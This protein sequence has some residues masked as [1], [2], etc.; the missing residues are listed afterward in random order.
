MTRSATTARWSGGSEASISSAHSAADVGH[1]LVLDVTGGERL[2]VEA[3]RGGARTALAAAGVVDQDPVRDREQPR[4][5]VRLV[6]RELREAVE[7]PQEHLAGE[8]LRLGCALRPQVAEHPSGVVSNSQ[9]HAHGS[10]LSAASCSVV[11]RVGVTD[12]RSAADCHLPGI[13]GDRRDA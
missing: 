8:V 10:R 9:R 5:E 2:D 13:G 11:E 1:R 12:P 7:H 6:A 3:E 4:A